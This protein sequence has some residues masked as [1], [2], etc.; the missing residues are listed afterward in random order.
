MQVPSCPE[1]YM[2]F[3]ESMFNLFGTKWL[4]LHCGPM[5][6]F[7]PVMQQSGDAVDPQQ[8]PV[9]VC[10]TCYNNYMHVI[11]FSQG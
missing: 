5:W 2:L 1:D 7:Q 8:R 10:I 6:A 3:L 4:K 9:N 11:I